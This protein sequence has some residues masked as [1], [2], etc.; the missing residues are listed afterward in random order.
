MYNRPHSPGRELD[1]IDIVENPYSYHQPI[2]NGNG[3]DSFRGHGHNNQEIAASF[4]NFINN[5]GSTLEDTNLK[6]GESILDGSD[7]YSGSDKSRE[8]RNKVGNIKLSQSTC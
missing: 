7:S 8:H 1:R 2:N 6:D 3:Y 5:S 4:D